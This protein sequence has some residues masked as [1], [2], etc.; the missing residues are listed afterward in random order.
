MNAQ[1]TLLRIEMCIR[2][3]DNRWI[4]D[5]KEFLSKAEDVVNEVKELKNDL[6]QALQ[7]KANNSK[8]LVDETHT[9]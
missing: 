3:L 8:Q 4:V 1:I 6:Q 5:H 9:A 7:T 2:D